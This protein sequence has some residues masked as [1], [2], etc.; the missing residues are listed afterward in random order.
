MAGILLSSPLII[1][2]IGE[3]F[4]LVFEDGV[5]APVFELEVLVFNFFLGFV[6]VGVIWF[7]Q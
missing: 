7:H 3:A 4:S 6:V 2:L 5:V 1:G